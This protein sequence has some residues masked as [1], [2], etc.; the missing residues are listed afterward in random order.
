MKEDGER[1]MAF[2]GAANPKA[3]TG[4]GGDST[5]IGPLLWFHMTVKHYFRSPK[6]KQNTKLEIS[7]GDIRHQVL[8]AGNIIECMNGQTKLHAII[9][10]LSIQSVI[11]MRIR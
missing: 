9:R 2:T 11:H 5:E 1:M 8:R 3:R 4:C 6:D 10:Q 7:G